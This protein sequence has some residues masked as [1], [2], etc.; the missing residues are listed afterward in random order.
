MPAQ[1]TLFIVDVQKGFINGWTAPIPEAV[2]ALQADFERV[3]VSRFINPP[4]SL[5][6]KL[7]G[8]DRF[9]PG[10]IDVEL[11]FAPQDGARIVDK[12]IYSALS[13]ALL[14]DLRKRKVARIYLAGIATDN[15]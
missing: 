8:W 3:V 12:E 7:I 15:P 9:A 6:R 14:D 10:S 5:Y 13:P 1:R 2:E 11:A 4:G